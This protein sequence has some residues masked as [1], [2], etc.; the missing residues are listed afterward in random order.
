[1]GK[2]FRC[3]LTVGLLAGLCILLFY[4]IDNRRAFQIVLLLPEELSFQFT[5]TKPFLF[6]SLEGFFEENGAKVKVIACY[7]RHG[8]AV[9]PLLDTL[10]LDPFP[11]VL[12]WFGDPAML[13]DSGKLKAFS[14]VFSLYP[15]LLKDLSAHT[16]IY[17]LYGSM[18][19]FATAI[20][21]LVES[22]KARHLKIIADQRHAVLFAQVPS[23]AE[24]ILNGISVDFQWVP[25]EDCEGLPLGA[26]ETSDYAGLPETLFLF[27]CEPESAVQIL[28]S[29]STVPRHRIILSPW[30]VAVDT[31]YTD[32]SKLEG[33]RFLLK[34][35]LTEVSTPFMLDEPIFP[36][37]AYAVEASKA[38]F[39]GYI[40]GETDLKAELYK[41]TEPYFSR[42]LQKHRHAL[43]ES[44][45]ILWEYAPEGFQ[46]RKCYDPLS[47]GWEECP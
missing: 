36:W 23:L 4:F 12:Y 35:S 17:S 47:L 44:G 28:R 38:F 42:L 19:S 33:I 34:P 31:L 18:E 25:V 5:A 41:G 37:A 11:K 39:T 43:Q 45:W 20:Q 46:K 10:A 15:I 9:D 3:C 29:W 21:R 32:T 7:Y 1:M 26:G 2:G 6:S 40:S 27:L 16:Q 14:L 24:N 13:K 30:S 22:E 8:E